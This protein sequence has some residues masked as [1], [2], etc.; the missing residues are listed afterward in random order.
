V[1]GAHVCT[2]L[3]D[4]YCPGCGTV[5][6]VVTPIPHAA[7]GEVGKGGSKP[8]P[9]NSGDS[10]AAVHDGYRRWLGD[11][12][13]LGALDCVLAAAAAEKLDGDPPWLLVIG[14]S[15]AAKT[16]TLMPLTGAEATVVS[17]ISGEAG[18]LSGT[19]AKERAA[20]ATGGLLSLLGHRGLLVIK[21]F[22]SILSM[23]RDTRAL[24]LAALREIYDGRWSRD[25][26]AEG[27]RTLT[28]HGRLVMIGA[29]TTAW[30]RAY[31]V[32]STMGD[33][34]ALVRLSSDDG[35]RRTAGLQAMRN[36]NHETQMR[37]EL[38]ELVG[39]L[40][41]GAADA[42]PDLDDQELDGL[43]G[44]ADLVTRGRTPVERDHQGNPLF[45]HALEMPTR[46]AKQLVQLARGGLALG[47]D[48]ATALGLA[49][50]CAADTLPPLRLRALADVA[51]NPDTTTADAVKRLQLPRTTVDR[52][53]QELH[54]LG[55][56]AVDE[57]S[58]GQ[59][60]R[61]TYALAPGTDEPSLTRLVTG[62]LRKG[63]A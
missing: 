52:T 23:N 4:G 42:V 59:R 32:V 53:L 20:D 7:N 14:G 38:A 36:V 43:L 33:R 56:L 55:L 31:Q 26:G 3:A 63:E 49:A 37:A 6:R 10:L 44:L 11:G 19:P 21:D 54:L 41:A 46:Y 8:H 29:C 57:I 18:L 13:D 51:A 28:W 1:S 9:D 30:D 5:T 47:M 16:E 17:T 35:H 58:V 45:A 62:G 12:Y 61:W 60:V 27:G 22:T 2:P 34:F 50:R 39:G 40:L 15:G 24:V 48:R 25:V